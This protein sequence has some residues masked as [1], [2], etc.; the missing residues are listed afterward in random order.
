MIENIRVGFALGEPH[1]GG[2]VADIVVRPDVPFAKLMANGVVGE[3]SPLAVR[4]TVISRNSPDGFT[5]NTE[6]DGK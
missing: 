2:S 3:L 6:G 1:I 4:D 5:A